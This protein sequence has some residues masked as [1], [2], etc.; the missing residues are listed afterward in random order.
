MYFLERVGDGYFCVVGAGA[1]A[2]AAVDA[3][4][5]DNRGFAVA[6]PYRFGW[7]GPDTVGASLAFAVEQFN[8]VEVAHVVMKA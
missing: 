7:A 4:V 6:D 1:Y 5:G 2:L 3:A 8:R